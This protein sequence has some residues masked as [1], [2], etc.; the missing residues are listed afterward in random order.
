MVSAVYFE[1]SKLWALVSAPYY[2]H[3]SYCL[4]VRTVAS[5]LTTAYDAGWC[6]KG[7]HQIK[8]WLGA[9]YDALVEYY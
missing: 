9:S 8:G 1:V 6:M 7:W 5:L 2:Y 3:A 4:P